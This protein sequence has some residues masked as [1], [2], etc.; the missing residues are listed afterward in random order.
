MPSGPLTRLTSDGTVNDRPE[1]TPDG[2]SVLFRSNRGRSNAIWIQPVDGAGNARVLHADGA[3]KI[4]EGVMSNDGRYLLLQRD[5]TGVADLWYRALTGDSTIKP[6]ETSRF[7]E[8]SGRFSPDGKWV[9]YSSTETGSSQVYVRAFPSMDA[10]YQV[11]LDGGGTPVWS[12]DS[13]RIYYTAGRDLMVATIGTTPRFAVTSRRRAI[14]GQFTFLPIHADFDVLPD[15]ESIVAFRPIEQDAQLV[16]V[17]NWRSELRA[18]A[19]AK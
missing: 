5:S 7:A 13:K 17:N 1:W 14:N 11:S 12:R 18:R 4:D 16:M 3:I 19:V 15:D 2:K 8:L 10:R 9:A 6:I